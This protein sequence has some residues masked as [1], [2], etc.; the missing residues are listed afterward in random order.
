MDNPAFE[1]CVNN[2]C[3]AIEYWKWFSKAHISYNQNTNEWATKHE[4]PQY[5][6]GVHFG[7]INKWKYQANQCPRCVKTG[8]KV[9]KIHNILGGRGLYVTFVVVS[10]IQLQADIVRPHGIIKAW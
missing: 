3:L 10:D 8:G 2:L 4:I 7:M 6:E 5:I 9:G 1:H